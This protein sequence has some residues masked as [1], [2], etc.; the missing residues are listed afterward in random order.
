MITW[1]RGGADLLLDTGLS[2]RGVMRDA[3]AQE[4][5][6]SSLVLGI[7]RSMPFQMRMKP[8]ATVN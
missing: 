3:S 7:V 4:Y 8:L 6:F 5:R 2:V 1:V